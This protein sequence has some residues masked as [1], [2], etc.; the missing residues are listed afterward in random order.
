MKKFELIRKIFAIV[1]RVG[2]NDDKQDAISEYTK[3]KMIHTVYVKKV[4]IDYDIPNVDSVAVT[5]LE[6]DFSDACDSDLRIAFIDMN[7]GK[8]V[9]LY[10]NEIE[11]PVLQVIYEYLRSK[12]GDNEDEFA[13]FYVKNYWDYLDKC[14]E[15]VNLP[16]RE[17]RYI[18][19]KFKET[20]V[21]KK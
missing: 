3:D 20:F 16:N 8:R 6:N 5:A 18:L 21:D 4:V 11:Y 19:D 17:L 2:F 10:A 14:G 13:Y 7:I 12:F 15:T 9:I 1:M